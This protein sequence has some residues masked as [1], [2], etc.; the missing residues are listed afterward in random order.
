MIYITDST[1]TKEITSYPQAADPIGKADVSFL[2]MEDHISVKRILKNSPELCESHTVIVIDQSGS[3][4]KSDVSGYKNR[5]QAVFSTLALEFVE[6]ALLN[7]DANNTDTMSIIVMR[8]TG[9]IILEKEPI[10]S[11]LF[12]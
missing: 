1:K 10:T 3:M 5:L 2:E 6:Q 12:N 11:V 4:R 7:G 8:E 9:D